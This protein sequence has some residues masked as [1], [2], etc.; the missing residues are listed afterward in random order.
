MK[1]LTLGLRLKGQDYLNKQMTEAGEV[2]EHSR[3]CGK[4]N[5]SAKAPRQGGP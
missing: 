3:M 1:R 2:G 5:G 4:E